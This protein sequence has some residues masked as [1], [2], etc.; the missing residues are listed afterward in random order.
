M[1]VTYARHP[2]GEA[3]TTDR[4]AL[5]REM[6]S[7]IL[8]HLR[9]WLPLE[10]CGLVASIPDEAG[11]Q[12]AVRFYPGDNLDRSPVRYTMDPRQVMTALD[13]M[14]E[15]GWSFGGIVHSHPRTPAE[16]SATDIGEAYYPGVVLL[17]VSF[18]DETPDIRA[19]RIDAGGGSP[20]EV[21]ILLHDA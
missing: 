9:A 6:M 11:G 4:F 5:P 10:G 1:L 2:E 8:K 20:T 19:W 17:I 21:P 3:L 18:A 12:R 7:D 15:R 13:E 14:D 16:P